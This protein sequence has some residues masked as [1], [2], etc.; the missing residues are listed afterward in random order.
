MGPERGVEGVLQPL[1]SLR[2]SGPEH[3]AGRASSRTGYA[4][5]DGNQGA[6]AVSSA[7]VGSQGV[8]MVSDCDKQ[9]VHLA[10][11]GGKKYHVGPID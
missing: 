7:L 11:S 6:G 9:A 8:Q 10:P 1:S 3:V 4:V 5:G 2:R